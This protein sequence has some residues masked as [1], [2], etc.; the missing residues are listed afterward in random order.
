MHELH[1]FGDLDALFDPGFETVNVVLDLAEHFELL[2]HAA[3]SLL[4]QGV[5][6]LEQLG[7]PFGCVD[8]AGIV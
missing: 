3:S 5:D 7:A 6:Q 8:V 4:G 1:A 2:V